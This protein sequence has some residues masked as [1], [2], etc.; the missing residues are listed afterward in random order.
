MM[1]GPWPEPG[2]GIMDGEISM[3][4]LEKKT[5]DLPAE[6]GVYLYKDGRGDIIYVGK[7]KSLRHR[8][9]SY[10]Q[11]S[12]QS[13]IK[14]DQLRS[15]ISDLECI[16]V[17][18]EMEA[19]ALEN[20]LIKQHKPKYNILLRDDKTYPCIKLSVNEPF[21]RISVT[22]RVK[23]DGAL[24]FGP[25]FPA[26]LA[27]RIF[28]LMSRHFQIRTCSI[29]IDGRRPRVCLDYHI[30]R[31][32]GPCVASVCSREEYAGRVQDLRWFME[33]KRRELVK[34]LR[35]KMLKAADEERFELAAHLRDMIRTI[36]QLSEP[37]RM[38]SNRT[39][40]VDVFALHREENQAAVQL[41]HLRSGRVVD[42]HQY[43]WEDLTSG[44]TRGEILAS[45][46]KQHY[47]SSSFTP[48]EVLVS[49]GFEDQAILASYLSSRKGRKV[50]VKEPRRG[51]KKQLLDLAHK[52]A[53]LTFN[54]RFRTLNPGSQLIR[55]ALAE[56][57][58]LENPPRRIE[59]F[60][61]SNIQGSDCVACMVV[62]QDGRMKKADYRK[63]IIKTVDGPDDF[64]SMVEVISRRYTRLLQE[65]RVLP[66]LV[67][68]DGGLGQ[69]HAAA[70]ALDALDLTTQPLASIAKKE[71]LIYVRG[72]EQ[73]P[74]HLPRH[75]PV[76][77]LIQRIRDETH[78][79]AVTFHRRRRSGRTLTSVLT[80]ISGVGDKTAKRLLQRLGSVPQIEA[81]SLDR[82]SAETSPRVA[83][84][85]YD[86]FHQPGTSAQRS[87]KG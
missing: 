3:Q 52:N 25:F 30:K 10:F 56:L 84:N 31:C 42:R 33:G 18:N 74:I 70:A 12:R 60:D 77:R 9:R 66:D 43:F 80:Q 22:R 58:D 64:K 24:Y 76:L 81:A 8:V 49:S 36:D 83:R 47:F 23:S 63:F 19:L 28:K 26:S 20:N 7:A 11:D 13:D 75:S 37:Q 55:E 4:A 67:L 72:S 85:I 78:R 79:F 61:V 38:S 34:S 5:S 50:A 27:S 40:D 54:Q 32:M 73:E 86:H 29:D 69:L 44:A 53:R 1:N 82:L 68:V 46:L 51:P 39:V 65:R 15:E 21:P 6:P 59:S 62:W 48:D 45:L 41:F 16:V 14:L 71:E 2:H 17:D 35:G 57:M 87:Q